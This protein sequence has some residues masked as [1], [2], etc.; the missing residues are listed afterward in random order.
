MLILCSE[1]FKHD[2][3]AERAAG[4][5]QIHTDRLFAPPGLGLDSASLGVSL[6]D[7]NS[8]GCSLEFINLERWNLY[9]EGKKM[10]PDFGLVP[11][12]LG[13]CLLICSLF[14]SKQCKLCV[15]GLCV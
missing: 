1:G 3:P 5:K 12:G 4:A 15:R 8:S 9:Q 10:C 2:Q 11:S 7:N 14:P 6:L 13:V